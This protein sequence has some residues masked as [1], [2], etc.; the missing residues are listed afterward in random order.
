MAWADS[1]VFREI[2]GELWRANA[3]GTGFDGLDIDVCK[4]ALFNNSVVPDNDSTI[5]NSAY[6]AGTW[7]VANEKSDT[8]WPAGGRPIASPSLSTATADAVFYDVA[9]TSGAGNVTLA[10]VHGCLVYDDEITATNVDAGI[11]YN[12]FGGAQSV[13]AGTFTIVWH[14]NGV[15]RYTL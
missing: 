9:D 1:K 2:I 11:C 7:L 10:D 5:A 14:A 13:T 12:Y 15:W 6:N 8:N 4:V 3:I